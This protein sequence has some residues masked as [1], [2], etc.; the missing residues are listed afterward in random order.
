MERP[1]ACDKCGKKFS[2]SDNLTQH[3]R[4][5][6]KDGGVGELG[7]KD[8]GDYEGS[9]EGSAGDESDGMGLGEIDLE[10]DEG[11][12]AGRMPVGVF[13]EAGEV[14]NSPAPFTTNLPTYG[15]LDTWTAPSSQTQPAEYIAPHSQSLP[16]PI[17]DSRASFGSI[18]GAD[19]SP[20]QYG[21]PQQSTGSLLPTHEPHAIQNHA[22]QLLS[23]SSRPRPTQA[24]T[25]DG[26]PMPYHRGASLQPPA[27]PSYRNR[28][29][30]ASYGNDPLA[31]S[32][33]N[34]IPP[35]NHVS[36][37]QNS[38]GPIRRHRSATP[39]IRPGTLPH[40]GSPGASSLFALR[41]VDRQ[42]SHGYH[43]YLH[44]S[45]RSR[46]FSTTSSIGGVDV[47]DD[48]GHGVQVA[49]AGYGGPL[50]A[51][52]LADGGAVNMPVGSGGSVDYYQA[53]DNVH[54][55]DNGGL[56]GIDGQILTSA[57]VSP[58]GFLGTPDPQQIGA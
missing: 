45:S 37:L 50:E 41:S 7:F 27:M 13:G 35:Y 9:G 42:N 11:V 46:D 28:T 8:G 38:I 30:F 17:A 36:S 58:N 31:S 44:G 34:F 26:Y 1:F 10:Q 57:D 4:T 49:G 16:L 53:V 55:V 54:V 24:V 29:D 15:S 51:T 2:R 32:A 19:G 47:H 22:Q 43:P 6:S 18:H 21:S 12:V 48:A 5:H 39:T 25:S 52:T 20:L 56:Y 40:Y 14:H 23:R 33:S 3:L